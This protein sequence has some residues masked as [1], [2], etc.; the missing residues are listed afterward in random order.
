MAP[1][2]SVQVVRFLMRNATRVSHTRPELMEKES[3]K[4][5]TMQLWGSR[6][7]RNAAFRNIWAKSFF[8][9]GRC[10]FPENLA[11]ANPHTCCKL[12]KFLRPIL[13]ASV[14]L[15]KRLRWIPDDSSRDAFGYYAFLR[16][17][18]RAGPNHYRKRKETAAYTF[19]TCAP[20]FRYRL[21]GAISSFRV[22]AIFLRFY[23]RAEII[24]D[25]SK[26]PNRPHRRVTLYLYQLDGHFMFPWVFDA[27]LCSFCFA[28]LQW[29]LISYF[30]VTK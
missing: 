16:N 4:N 15:K 19:R 23:K 24:S 14:L 2:A 25:P 9:C 7:F 6:S 12:L 18:W 22:I 17:P 11:R 26:L 27:R 13:P 29:S 21:A 10:H 8:F 5:R 3:T 20:Y 30:G 28:R 1:G